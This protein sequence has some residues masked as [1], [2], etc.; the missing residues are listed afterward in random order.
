MHL[1]ASVEN[2][3]YGVTTLTQNWFGLQVFFGQN[4]VSEIKEGEHRTIRIGDMVQVA[5]RSTSVGEL[6]AG[7]V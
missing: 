1:V 3:R 4:V 2:N 7:L 5:V 6:M